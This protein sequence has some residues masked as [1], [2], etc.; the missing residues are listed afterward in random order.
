MIHPDAPEKHCLKCHIKE[1]VAQLRL[2]VYECEGGPLE[3]NISFRELCEIADEHPV[4]W[5]DVWD[6]EVVVECDC[7]RYPVVAR[8]PFD[9]AD[10]KRPAWFDG[11]D[12]V[13]REM[14]DDGKELGCALDAWEKAEAH[15]AR[16]AAGEI[17][18]DY[19]CADNEGA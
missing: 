2:C 11:L 10:G 13:T 8:F 17:E 9:L 3:N 7:P 6:N 19:V 15:V 5:P 4:Y 1:I 14:F 16:L 12:V 18:P